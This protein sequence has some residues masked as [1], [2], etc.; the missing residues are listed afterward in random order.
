MRTACVMLS[1]V[2]CRVPAPATAA[3]APEAPQPSAAPTVEPEV[4][5]ADHDP[6]ADASPPAL[7]NAEPRPRVEVAG[8]LGPTAVGPPKK[9]ASEATCADRER[10]A[11]RAI[12]ALSRGCKTADDCELRASFCPFGCYRV[13]SKQAD[14]APAER[15]LERFL[16]GCRP[17]KYKCA[18]R[19]ESL[20][21]LD[22][23]C[24]DARDAPR[25]DDDPSVKAILY[26]RDD[27]EAAAAP[28]PDAHP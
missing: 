4:A 16:Q 24:V 9:N 22:G 1:L 11:Q 21:C 10:R 3:S 12:K 20:A 8:A 2:G 26:G 17:C 27:A 15:A 7:P 18:L 6:P 19:P 25:T 13:L 5:P 28:R 23:V 14:R